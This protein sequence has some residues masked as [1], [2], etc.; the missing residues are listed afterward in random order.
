MNY[1]NKNLVDV[2]FQSEMEKH[3]DTSVLFSPRT[4]FG[5]VHHAFFGSVGAE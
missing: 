1:K 3:A 5:F 2:S 4:V